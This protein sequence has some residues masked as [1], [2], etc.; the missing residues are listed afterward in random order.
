MA[1]APL[2]PPPGAPKNGGRK[3]FMYAT[4]LTLI[5]G[6]GEDH[7]EEETKIIEGVKEEEAKEAPV[8]IDQKKRKAKE[9]VGTR[10]KKI[11]KPI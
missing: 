7:Q 2:L 10:S 11:A 8:S 4:S 3:T 1:M 6:Q 9:Q 5:E